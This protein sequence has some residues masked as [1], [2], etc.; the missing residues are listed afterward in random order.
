MPV[1]VLLRSVKGARRKLS[2]VLGGTHHFLWLARKHHAEARGRSLPRLAPLAA[3][4]GALLRLSLLVLLVLVVERGV[5]IVRQHLLLLLWVLLLRQHL[6]GH[7]VLC[8]FWVLLSLAMRRHGE[9]AVGWQRPVLRRV[10]VQAL[11]A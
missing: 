7:L 8:H 10:L 6:L 1:R 9:R 2:C 11:L 3:E 4:V 5:V